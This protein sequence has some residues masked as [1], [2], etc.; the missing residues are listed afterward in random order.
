MK[1][2]AAKLFATIIF[3]RNQKWIKNPIE[4]QEKTFQKL[5]ATARETTFGRDHNFRSI[6]TPADFFQFVPIRDYEELSPYIDRMVAGEENILWP[7]KPIYFSKTSGTTS[8]A[9]YIPITKESMPTHIT[10]ARDALLNYIYRTGKTG[11]LKGKQIFIQGSP[12]LEDKKGVALGRLSGIVAHYVPRYLQKSRMPSWETNCIEDWEHKVDTIVEETLTKNMTLI[13]GIPSWVQMYFEKLK[14]KT[15][16]NVGDIFKDFSLLVY[17]G[18]NFEPY[19]SVFNNLIGRKVDTIEL[20]PASEGFFAYQDLTEQDGLLLLLN[21]DIFY[22]FIRVDQIQQENPKR[23]LLHEIELGVNYALIIST[24]AGLWAYNIGDTVLFVSKTPFRLVVTGRIK[25]FISAF[26]EHVIGKE[27]E[28]ALKKATEGT[29]I[30]VR[31]F[32]VA[33]QVKPEKGLPYHEWC[34]EF[35]LPPNDIEAFEKVLDQEMEKQNVYYQDLIQGKVLRKLV[36]KPVAKQG[37]EA[38]MKSIGKLG[39]QNKVPRLSNDRKIADALQ[40]KD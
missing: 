3:R 38:Y 6:K 28:T 20:F 27:V 23:Y 35:D 21:N 24:S 14:K 4:S 22:E 15:N 8:G 1:Q 30:R 25:H 2:I 17:G 40:K 9:K 5:I 16:K 33:P 32:T 11:F 19:K 31:E 18:V 12:K 37:F 34:I 26:G 29:D 7:G 39:G 36:I 13:G 10:A